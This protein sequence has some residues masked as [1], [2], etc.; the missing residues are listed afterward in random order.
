MNIAVVDV[1]AESGGAAS[2]L[3]YF[4]EQHRRDKKNHYVYLLSTYH[5]D[6][7]ENITVVNVPWVK[8]GWGSR[9]Y[10]DFFGVNRYLKQYGINEVLSLQNTVLP[11]FKGK[12]T[13]YEHN[14]LP[15][16]E[17]KF[18]LFEDRRMWIY[19]NVI[20]KFILYAI[21]R[22]DHVIVQTEW[23]KRAVT[24][25]IPGSENKTEVCFPYVM[26]PEIYK[27]QS[28][29]KKL[30]FYPANSSRFKNH[31]LIID[32]CR[33]LKNDGYQDYSVIFTLYGNE[34]KEIS[35]L[36]RMS[37]EEELNIEW[38]GPL[39]SENVYKLY[40]RSVLVFPS[41]IETIGLP[42]YEASV[43]GSPILAADCQYARDL[44]KDY[45]KVFFFDYRDKDKLTEYMELLMKADK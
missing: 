9:L 2:V 33:I 12:Q 15:F 27:Y 1:A 7:T 43:I 40:E 35:E 44:L 13:V 42:L 34:T 16:S 19:Q 24:E 30:F 32:A 10:F 17:Y 29:G 23:M 11:G 39:P 45:D 3:E 28:M 8:K 26:I 31:R 25:R 4:Y 37:R 5:L 21:R 36:H 41:Y 14:A 6:E 20:G 18:S 22:A 38:A